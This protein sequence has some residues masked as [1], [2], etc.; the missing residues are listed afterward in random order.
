MDLYQYGH[1]DMPFL[2]IESLF[3]SSSST[4]NSNSNIGS[5]WTQYTDIFY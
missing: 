3:I 1:G 2:M 5:N 4:G